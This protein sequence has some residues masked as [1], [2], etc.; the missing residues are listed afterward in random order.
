MAAVLY[1]QLIDATTREPPQPTAETPCYSIKQLCIQKRQI[2]VWHLCK[3]KEG[4]IQL[5]PLVKSEIELVLI[6]IQIKQ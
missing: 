6:G 1:S 4:D 2:L 3:L 5:L